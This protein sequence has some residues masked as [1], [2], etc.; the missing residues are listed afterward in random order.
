MTSGLV[1]PVTVE[2]SFAPHLHASRITCEGAQD[3]K[4]KQLR[5][6]KT[7][8]ICMAASIQVC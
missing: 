7:N 2:P 5:S 4:F 8:F 6:I 1:E 3:K